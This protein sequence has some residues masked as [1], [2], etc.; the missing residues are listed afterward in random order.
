MGIG[1]AMKARYSNVGRIKDGDGGMH[2]GPRE[3]AIATITRAVLSSRDH[4][5][6]DHSKHTGASAHCGIPIAAITTGPGYLG[7]RLIKNPDVSL[8]GV[9]CRVGAR[10]RHVE[11]LECGI[12]TVDHTPC[13]ITVAAIAGAVISRVEQEERPGIRGKPPGNW[14]IAPKQIFSIEVKAVRDITKN[15]GHYPI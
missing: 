12:A 4:A 14:R 2:Q 8:M 7:R 15:H 1:V 10:L 5:G 13:K 3:V 11:R 9:G 6:A